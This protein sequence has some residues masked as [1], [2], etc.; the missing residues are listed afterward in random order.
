MRRRITGLLLASL[1]IISLAA[2]RRTTPVETDATRADATEKST[3]EP[4]TQTAPTVP[5]ED[6]PGRRTLFS[7]GGVTVS[8]SVKEALA[9]GFTG[10]TFS[11]S[12][13]DEDSTAGAFAFRLEKETDGGY[14]TITGQV[15]AGAD[16]S[17]LFD[18][19]TEEEDPAAG[20]SANEYLKEY[21]A[22]CLA[23]DDPDAR[24]AETEVL[25]G[26]IAWTYGTGLIHAPEE[27]TEIANLYAFAFQEPGVFW[28][29]AGAVLKGAKDPEA[30]MEEVKA[31]LEEWLFTLS[32]ELPAEEGGRMAIPVGDRVF[33]ADVP[34]LFAYPG[35]EFSFASTDGEL[36]L[37]ASGGAEGG[38]TL[39]VTGRAGNDAPDVEE[40]GFAEE[41]LEEALMN[42]VAACGW[43]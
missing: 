36:V 16:A 13:A 18:F 33:T 21:A 9:G 34:D 37:T 17:P 22:E 30:V 15:F 8:G 31:G 40:A 14:L 2:C 11:R 1:M 38:F 10:G 27:E 41:G 19:D 3:E 32:A 4:G 5:D 12:D 7:A 28:V 23:A 25:P 26:Y 35:A 42:W 29:Q 24:L 39:T 43:R 6:P 20:R